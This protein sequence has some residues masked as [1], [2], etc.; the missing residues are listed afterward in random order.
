LDKLIDEQFLKEREA[1]EELQSIYD[2]V[3]S[4]ETIRKKDFSTLENALGGSWHEH[5][6]TVK[7]ITE[8]AYESPVTIEDR[9]PDI[10]ET[11]LTTQKELAVARALLHEVVQLRYR[12]VT[13]SDITSGIESASD[14][15][16]N[17][18]MHM[19]SETSGSEDTLPG[20]GAAEIQLASRLRDYADSVPGREALVVEIV[21]DAIEAVPAQYASELGEDPIDVLVELRASAQDGEVTAGI[22]ENGE[23]VEMD[24]EA[25]QINS[26]QLFRELNNSVAAAELILIFERNPA[27]LLRSEAVLAERM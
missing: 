21:A 26:R 5:T 17:D 7:I 27:Q 12:G 9:Y 23:V 8:L 19:S 16:V 25:D 11:L 15:Y 18:I 14:R 22:S 6:G 20:G 2:R 3:Q 1:P 4:G 10:V 13:V 24:D